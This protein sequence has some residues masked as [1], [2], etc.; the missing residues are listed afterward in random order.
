LK[1]RHG[2]KIKFSILCAFILHTT[3]A[4]G[5]APSTLEELFTKL[6]SLTYPLTA[7][8]KALLD[9]NI[10]R[11]YSYDESMQRSSISWDPTRAKLQTHYYVPGNSSF[12]KMSSKKQLERFEVEVNGIRLNILS[13][14]GVLDRDGEF[15][16]ETGR[17]LEVELKTMEGNQLYTI[18]RFI[19]GQAVLVHEKFKKTSKELF[20]K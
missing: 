8:E 19:N 6:N 13:V 17:I 12:L 10:N 18:G 16:P 5:Q 3:L 20:T 7:F 15:W 14:F 9:L 4:Y 2:Y 11:S 1:N